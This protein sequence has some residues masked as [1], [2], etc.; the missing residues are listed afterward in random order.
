[1]AVSTLE[2]VI[3][4]VIKNRA[5][6]CLDIGGGNDPQQG[7]VN[8]DIRPLE[9][10]DIVHDLEEFPWPLPDECVLTALASHLIEHINPHRGVFIRFMDE[11]WRVMKVGGRF[12][13]STPYAGSP[14]Y[15]QDPSHINPCNQTTFK[16]FTPAHPL[17][18]KY[19][20]K[21]WLIMPNT[22]SWQE[23]GNLECV[24]IKVTEEEVVSNG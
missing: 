1:M 9:S 15:F 8:M 5:G 11:V 10:V 22:L 12:I 14:G 2:D 24:M 18:E 6:I 17:Y 19:K 4:Q 23:N 16:Y 20:P 13:I 3:E 7:F 21:P